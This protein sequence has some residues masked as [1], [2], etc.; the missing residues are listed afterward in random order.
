MASVPLLLVVVVVVVPPLLS[1]V[2]ACN[3][4][5]FLASDGSAEHGT[6]RR[7]WRTHWR[8]HAV[9]QHDDDDDPSSTSSTSAE[10]SFDGG[11]MRSEDHETR[12]RRRQ[13]TGASNPRDGHDQCHAHRRS[14]DDDPSSTSSTSAEVSFD[15]G[16]MRSEDHETRP[17]RRQMSGASNPRDGHDQRHAH[18]RSRFSFTRRCQQVVDSHDGRTRYLTTHRQLGESESKFICI[19]FVLRSSTVL[20]VGMTVVNAEPLW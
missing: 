3:F 2:T 9:R 8:Q 20:Q 7:D 4:P 17:R 11:I 15:G 12:P 13:M 16:I 6:A 10:V 5:D 19:E 18:R 1:D 14:R